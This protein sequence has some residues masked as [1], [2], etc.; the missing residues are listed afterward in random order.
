MTATNTHREG[1]PARIIALRNRLGLSQRRLAA[2]LGVSEL[3]VRRW[4]RGRSRPSQRTWQHLHQVERRGPTSVPPT[5][6]AVDRIRLIGRERELSSITNALASARLVTLT[7]AGGVGKT[8]LARATAATI[9]SSFPGSMWFVD[10][11]PSAEPG[12]VVQAV[13]TALGVR[14][15]T[16]QP[17]IETLI[18]TLAARSTLIV[19]DN[20]EHLVE[21]VATL[22]D[23]L[24]DGCPRVRLLA[25]SRE[26][27]GVA[28]ERVLTVPPLSTEAAVALFAERARE[29]NPAFALTEANA[30]AIERI[31]QRLDG[32]PLA[33]ELAAARVRLL[34]VEQ[35]EAHLDDRLNLLSSGRRTGP[36]RHRS[37]AAAMS[38]S[39]DLLSAAERRLFLRLS[40][41]AGYFSLAAA[42]WL[43]DEATQ[44]DD[45]T[46]TTL[47]LL[48]RLVDK[49]LVVTEPHG[50]AM[51]HR[52]LE[53][54][55]VYGREQ[56]AKSNDLESALRRHA[57]FCL[58][59]ARV[60]APQRGL[61]QPAALA[62]LDER[63]D[64]I[65]AALAWSTSATGE[66]E[67]AQ[68]FALAMGPYW[69]A[70]GYISEG[71]MWT[72][73]ALARESHPA[74]RAT[75]LR[76]AAHLARRQTDF[77]T[78]HRALE[79]ALTLERERDDKRGI[80]R[81][82]SELSALLFAEGDFTGSRAIEAETLPMLRALGDE[83][84][85][86][87]LLTAIGLRA[88][89]ERDIP[90]ARSAL[91]EVVA[92][93]RHLN[94]RDVLGQAL[95]NRGIVE[96]E[97]GHP[98]DAR[99]WLEECLAVAR[100]LGDRLVTAYAL[101]NL[102]L[103]QY[104][105]G[106]FAQAWEYLLAALDIAV[107]LEL[108]WEIASLLDAFGIV[109]AAAGNNARAAR[110]FGAADTLLATLGHPP[111]RFLQEKR[112]A[113][114]AA[115][116]DALGP[117]A[118]LAA[119]AQGATLPRAAIVDDVRQD[120]VLAPTPHIFPTHAAPPLVPQLTPRETEI[121]YGLTQGWSTS[122][123]A[124]T[125]VLSPRTVERHL[126]NL[127]L[128]LGVHSRAEAIAL[129]FR[130]DLVSQPQS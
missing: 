95:H 11:A 100:N 59:S 31:C 76:L 99:R 18:S 50:A 104:D 43:N 128:K 96:L 121:L 9:A 85:L 35:I 24:L 103:L 49:S 17:L 55:R 19:L 2:L 48:A 97:A 54:L 56:L 78:A 65:R 15:R 10:L 39:I 118:Y 71:R 102:G 86:I 58:Q 90:T 12:F 37:L 8:R 81:T 62:Q 122:T 88:L 42:R 40:V 36:L 106:A 53:T 41:F 14:E 33:I 66:T 120:P 77:A 101:C 119:Y 125:L 80:A 109:A 68:Q 57:A 20:C 130:A 91:E 113:I 124:R 38:W 108:P 21:A 98:H 126:S 26:P 117:A 114:R 72:E 61:D 79:E 45:G 115:V 123:I 60:V 63:I 107:T 3:T 47:D 52:L 84:G 93:A 69:L 127:Y 70:R 74:L 4:E 32:L 83:E 16:G 73:R 105:L 110:L 28:G 92:I 5:N 22:A 29:Q 46:D 1:T 34:A 129:A 6:L 94:R 67:T 112:P 116:R 82:L 44:S 75:L 30:G 64:D 87:Q 13:A 51:R 111:L 25:T 23:R 27:L 89:A 7:G